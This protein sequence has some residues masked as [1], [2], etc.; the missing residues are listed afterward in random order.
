MLTLLNKSFGYG[1]HRSCGHSLV[2]VPAR[3]LPQASD[4]HLTESRAALPGDSYE[5]V[6]WVVHYNPET[7]NRSQPNKNYIGVSR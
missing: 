2:S 4:G 1:S 7:E 5:V 6:F 3:R